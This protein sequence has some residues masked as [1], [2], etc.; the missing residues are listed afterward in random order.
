MSL[1][2]SSLIILFV[3]RIQVLNCRKSYGED[4]LDFRIRGDLAYYHECSLN[5]ADA[6]G[7]LDGFPGTNHICPAKSLAVNMIAAFLKALSR[8]V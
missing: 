7:P 5:F 1:A 6:A 3:L 2:T 8:Y 4:V